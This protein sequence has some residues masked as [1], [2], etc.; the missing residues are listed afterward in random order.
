LPIKAGQPALP[1]TSPDTTERVALPLGLLAAAGF[2]SSAGA[3]V[4]DPLLHAI[5][6]DFSVLVPDLWVVIAAF[7]LP[8]G[9]NQLLLGPVG[10][11]FGK[12]RVMLGALVG[13][14]LFTG[15]CAFAFNLTSLALLRACAGAASAGLIPVGMAYIG[16]AVPYGQRQVTLSKFLTGIVLAQTLAGPVGGIFGQYIGWRG[17]FLVLAGLAAVLVVAFAARIRGLPD[18]R[19]PGRMFKPE[20]Y[21]R[22]ATHRTGRLVLAAAALDGAFFVGCFPYLAPY[23]HEHFGLSYAQVGAILA[24]FGLGAWSYTRFA[25]PLLARLGE[26]GM[27]LA[28]GLLMAAA[29]AVAVVSGRW[30]L[31]VPVELALGLGFFMLHSVLQARATEMLPRAR[32]TAVATF[33]CLLFLGQSV[34]ALLVGIAIARFDYP[35]AFLLDAGCIVVLTLW[36]A[37]LVRR[38]PA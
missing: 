23:L 27:V 11:R 5:A 6:T 28:G 18:R 1:A 8:Y 21:V 29:L 34:G 15:A 12:L 30:W 10:D 9:L 33:A 37:R 24:C 25:R 17:V 36:L 26:G 38:G 31:F 32:A 7:T 16:D 13:Y 4:V 3:R 22:M 2:L 20:N 19:S 35:V 14:A